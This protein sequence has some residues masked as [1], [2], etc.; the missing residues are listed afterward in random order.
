MRAVVVLAAGKGTRMRSDRPKVLHELLG[1][2]LLAYPL[3]AASAVGVT[4]RVVVVGHGREKIRERFGG[5]ALGDGKSSGGLVWAVQDPQLGTGHAAHCGVE[6]LVESLKIGSSK[7]KLD[8]LQV[9]VLN[10]DLPLLRV[11]TLTALV[12]RHESSGAAATLLTCEKENPR[13][14]GRIVRAAGGAFE[15]IVEEPDADAATREIRE[16]N[17]GTY[18]FR[19]SAFREFFPR[20]KAEN[21]QGEY[22]LPDV[23][24]VAARAGLRVE[25]FSVEDETE[26]AQVNSRSEL[27]RAGEILRARILDDLMASGVTIDDPRTTYIESGVRIGR[28]SRILPFTVIQRG[29]E[30]GEN[31]EVGPFAHLR[32]GT[33]LEAHASIGNF[34]EIKK[35]VIGPGSKVRHLS[36]VGDGIVGRDVNI[37]AGTIFANYDG[38]RKSTT[39]VQDGAFI[40]SGTVLV[41]PVTIGKGARTGAGSVVLR[42][43]DVPDGETVAGVPAKRIEKVAQQT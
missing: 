42:N 23:A 26:T 34:V 15:T 11:E 18:V 16:V 41:A 36:Y 21:R 9:L 31:C 33:K 1:L 25:T 29:V 6:A 27:A 2:P 13:G 40:G 3:E 28:D 30:I 20:T 38:V 10:G 39:Q 22:Y 43:R 4:Q 8:D 5:S 14:Y 12:E 37:G 32:A 7:S 19:A 35:S 24:V 17:V